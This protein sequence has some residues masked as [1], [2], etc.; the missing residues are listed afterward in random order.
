MGDDG[1]V[2]QTIPPLRVALL[3][4]GTVGSNVARILLTNSHLASQVGRELLLTGVAV[5]DMS[6]PRDG[7]PPDLLTDDPWS[8]IDGAD[9]VIEVMGGIE[10]AHSL[11]LRAFSQGVS[12]VTAN[13]ALLAA[14]GPEL[15]G[16]AE[17]AGVD[18]YFE[19]AVAGAI[20]IIRPLR[21]SLI[22]DEILS[23]KGIVNGTTNFILDQMSSAALSFEQAFTIAQEQGWVEADPA[24]DVE[25]FDAAAKLSLLASLGFGAKILGDD[26]DREGIL[27]VTAE[28]IATARHLGFVV[29]LVAS[30]E[31]IPGH[32]DKIGVQVRPTMLPSRHPL[33]AVRGGDNAIV[34]ESRN[35]GRLMFLGPGAGGAPTASAVIGDLAAVARNR[36][37]GIH[38]PPMT[39]EPLASVADISESVDSFFV[40]MQVDDAPGVLSRVA[41]VFARHEVSISTVHQR[42]SA[43]DSPTALVA[44]TTHRSL[45]GN[46]RSA[47]DELASMVDVV[48]GGIALYR[49]E[50]D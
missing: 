32:P 35:A 24:A 2:T 30:A 21:E 47:I 41:A 11:L 15:F 40:S 7:V 46:V 25:G 27:S 8:L 42:P 4:C 6:R 19:A 36:V 13:K 29:K 39:G 22:G 20:P 28:D 37:R 14:H 34:V 9:I 17:A 48:H 10:P 26:V 1:P 5:R 23:L 31:P 45:H 43:A 12:V 18:L 16:A 44:I 3:G 49:V 33:A 38:L 50:A